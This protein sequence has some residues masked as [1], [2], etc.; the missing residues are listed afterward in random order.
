VKAARALAAL[1]ILGWSS[2]AL[3][4]VHG[5]ANVNYFN[6]TTDTEGQPSSAQQVLMENLMLDVE[7]PITPKL[8]YA[9]YLRASRVEQSSESGRVR[10]ETTLTSLEPDVEIGLRDAL[11]TLTSGYR[12]T[13]SW[14]AAHFSNDE[15]QTQHY[16]FARLSLTP[17]RLPMVNLQYDRLEGYDYLT[18]SQLQQTSDSLM[19]D[20]NYFWQPVRLYYSLNY[21]DSDNGAA[22]SE[23]P[24]QT[25]SWNHLGRVDYSQGLLG[26]KIPVAASYQVSSFNSN[27]VVGVTGTTAPSQ[28]TGTVGRFADAT[29]TTLTAGL[30][31]SLAPGDNLGFD[32]G[33][34][35]PRVVDELIFSPATTSPPLTATWQVWGAN[36]GGSWSFLGGAD[37]ALAGEAYTVTFANTQAFSFYKLVYASSNLA[38]ITLSSAGTATLRAFNTQVAAPPQ[39][40]SLSQT[41]NFNTAGQIT[42]DL[43]LAF[44]LYLDRLDQNGDSLLDAFGNLLPSIWKG[45]TSRPGGASSTSNVNRTFG[46]SL[47]WLPTAWA[48]VSLN[49]QRQDLFDS[50]QTN[51]LGGNN[52]SAVFNFTPLATLDTTLSWSRTEQK[53]SQ[54]VSDGSVR[55]GDSLSDAYLASLTAH[56]L[57]GLDWVGDLGYTTS[58]QESTSE[59]STQSDSYYVH[60]ILSA[61]I[62]PVLFSTLNYSFN[63][64]YS[65]PEM[66]RSKTGSLV[67]SYRPTA[68]VNTSYSVTGSDMGD[69]QLLAQSVSFDWLMLPA[70][71]LHASGTQASTYPGP[72]TSQNLLAQL[73]YYVNRYADLQLGYAFNR[74]KSPV[75][76]TTQSFNL[77]FNGR[78]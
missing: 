58:Q 21:R 35:T 15:R 36:L 11:Y 17:L 44:N 22:F 68:R 9:G 16:Y 63:W 74:S 47:R 78:F 57:P 12:R 10:S 48:A 73:V 55:Q 51:N 33:T 39:L 7:G 31:G 42:P 30:P 71:H 50:E 34:G 77:F 46:P 56:L 59:A 69:S 13:E 5:Y 40:S 25:T 52:Y 32:F 53:T 38:T 4:G 67:V 20:V 70:I 28:V 41:I 3:A 43:S 61:Q 29:T 76:S 18:P 62:T 8:G 72:T 19:L 24:G 26:G 66:T 75:E 37:A 60:G 23:A 65:G 45:S 49:Y 14:R 6:S 64:A 2:A 27:Q 54:R 1:L